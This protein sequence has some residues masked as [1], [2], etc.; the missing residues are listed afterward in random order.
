MGSKQHASKRIP[1][2]KRVT[3]QRKTAKKD[4]SPANGPMSVANEQPPSQPRPRPRPQLHS[5]PP[6]KPRVRDIPEE[7]EQAEND[8]SLYDI[9]ETFAQESQ[10]AQDAGSLALPSQ[11]DTESDNFVLD[12]EVHE[13]VTGMSLLPC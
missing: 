4:S 10:K 3:G 7:E 6:Y 1:A 13:T 2:S 9:A 5:R 12:E 8:V 11:S